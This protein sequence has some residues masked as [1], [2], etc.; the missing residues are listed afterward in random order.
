M[1]LETFESGDK[2]ISFVHRDQQEMQ[3]VYV[4]CHMQDQNYDITFQTPLTF[5]PDQQYTKC[6]I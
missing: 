1:A 2:T 5:L 4:L 3:E 6:Q